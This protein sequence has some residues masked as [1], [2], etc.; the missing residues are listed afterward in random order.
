MS[1]QTSRR[2]GSQRKNRPIK[3]IVL[4]AL[5]S[6]LLHVVWIWPLQTELDSLKGQ[7]RDLKSALSQRRGSSIDLSQS[8]QRLSQAR[9]RLE[10]LQVALARRESPAVM[11]QIQQLARSSDLEINSFVPLE[12]V[13]S[14][15][16][17]EHPLQISLEGSFHSL[18]RFLERVGQSEQIINITNLAIKGVEGDPNPGRSLRARLTASTFVLE[19]PGPDPEKETD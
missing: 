19:D 11:A 12:R 1:E 17:Q 4:T 3:I 13:G 14:R 8:I 7:E 18:G 10:Q 15:F 16:Y 5:V 6:I 9:T 2:S